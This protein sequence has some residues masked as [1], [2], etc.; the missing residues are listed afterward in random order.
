M[1]STFLREYDRPNYC[2]SKKSNTFD[3]STYAQELNDAYTSIS[4]FTQS[5]IETKMK[6]VCIANL[7]VDYWLLK[8]H[9]LFS[10]YTIDKPTSCK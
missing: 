5:K 3:R 2:I 6:N 1:E 8:K 4:A 7:D 9:E 10:G